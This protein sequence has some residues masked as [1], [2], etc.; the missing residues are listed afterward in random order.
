MS[1]IESCLAR[2]IALLE[3]PVNYTNETKIFAPEA[4]DPNGNFK[5]RLIARAQNAIQLGQAGLQANVSLLENEFFLGVEE[6]PDA[7]AEKRDYY[8]LV[9]A[10]QA[11]L[12]AINRSAV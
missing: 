7:D 3:P 12:S 11:L 8:T 10:T 1:N 4:D 2:L 9:N 5:L 6:L